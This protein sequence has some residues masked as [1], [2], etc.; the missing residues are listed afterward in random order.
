MVLNYNLPKEIRS[1]KEKNH[2][3]KADGK[4]KHQFL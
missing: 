3:L 4:V 2:L 1:E